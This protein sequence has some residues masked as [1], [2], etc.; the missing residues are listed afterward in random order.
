MN[1]AS[2]LIWLAPAAVGIVLTAALLGDDGPSSP[3]ASAPPDSAS[4]DAT[5]LSGD[6]ASSTSAASTPPTT[7]FAQRVPELP[8]EPFNYHTELPDHFRFNAIPGAD[9]RPVAEL[10]NTPASNPTTNAGAT[11]GRVLFYDVNLSANRT[12]RCAS[13]HVQ[14]NAFTDPL[15]F[16]Q[17]VSGR[18]TRRNSMGLANAAFNLQGRYFWD[19]RAATLEDQ[20]LEPFLDPIEMA[21]P[22]EIVVERITEQDYYQGLF[23][24]AFG[25]DAVTPERISAALAQFVR[26]MVSVDSRYDQ[27]R[28]EVDSPLDPF[29][30][31]SDDEN[32]GKELFYQPINDG[33]GGCSGCHTSEA[34]VSSPTGPKNNGIDPPVQVEQ[35]PDLGAFE[36]TNE[37]SDVGLFRVP[38]LRN[39]AAT[40]PYMHDGRFVTLDDVID[41][42]NEAIQPHENLSPELRGPNGPVR[43]NFDA[44]DRRDLVAFLD[45]LTD[46]SFLT[47]ER[48]SEPFRGF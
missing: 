3:P 26:A 10:D 48:F 8:T 25:D 21:I 31:F 33:G 34:H 41:H 29:P 2:W 14:V 6:N 7:S 37:L 23:Q 22:L 47:D 32:R 44:D 15:V 43:L 24:D 20:V 19:E 4:V 16:S 18:R 42:Y 1:R 30:N 5:S 46:D 17:G 45:A 38:S 39:I 9:Q 12:V 36:S 40:A 35:V 13:C 27:G 28:A 11:L